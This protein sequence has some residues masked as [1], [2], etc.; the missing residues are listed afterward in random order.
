MA[1]VELASLPSVSLSSWRVGMLD[2]FLESS[3]TSSPPAV[4]SVDTPLIL[5]QVEN[6]EGVGILYPSNHVLLT[7]QQRTKKGLLRSEDMDAIG[8]TYFLGQF[9]CV[10]S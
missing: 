4:C 8:Q 7:E 10:V 1:A 9:I 3:L 6:C 5:V 2:S